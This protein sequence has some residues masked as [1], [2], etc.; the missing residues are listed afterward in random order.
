MN[1]LLL[2]IW[3]SKA[4]KNNIVWLLFWHWFTKIFQA[5]SVTPFFW[6]QKMLENEVKTEGHLLALLRTCVRDVTTMLLETPSAEQK[7]WVVQRTNAVAFYFMDSRQSLLNPA[8]PCCNAKALWG[9]LV[10]WYRS[11]FV[12]EWVLLLPQIQIPPYGNRALHYELGTCLPK[13]LGEIKKI[14]LAG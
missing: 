10:V 4:S 9:L 6:V 13:Q 2:K 11:T 3:S 5:E 7:Y 14:Y 12:V 8:W 1:S